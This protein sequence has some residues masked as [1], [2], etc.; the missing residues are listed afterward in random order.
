VRI[1]YDGLIYKLQTTGGISRYFHNLISRLPENYL[2]FLTA[3]RSQTTR[4]PSHPHLKKFL[5]PEFKPKRLSEWLEKAY[6]KS[7]LS[8]H[9]FDVIHPTYYWMLTGQDMMQY[10]HPIVIT[11]HDMIHERF[12][13][14]MDQNNQLARTKQRAAQTANL[15]I[16][17][18]ENTKQDVLEHYSIPEEKLK[19]IH[20]AS[21]LDQSLAYGSE[22]I[23]S[24]PYFLYVGSRNPSYKNFYTLLKALA[25]VVSIQPDIGL[26]VVG[27]SFNA[28]EQQLIAELN[29]ESHINRYSSVD[30]RHLAK[31]Y[32]CSLAFVYPSLYE[33]FGIPPLEAMSCGTPVVASNRASIPEVVGDAGI[34]FEPEAVGDLADILLSLV[35]NPVERDRAIQKGFQRS[36]QFSWQKTITQT[37]EI[38]Q[39]LI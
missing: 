13:K 38:Y 33:G 6:F 4:Y 3:Y 19:V 26:C 14:G 20:L 21:E 7:I 17:V 31:L 28:V 12:A 24:R 11:L 8:S 25:K 5:F 15:I 32:R 37:S 18:S 35:E 1:F 10:L 27:S 2:P 9:Q 39:S 30:D 16:C 22:P 36:K 23:P 34:L 29:L